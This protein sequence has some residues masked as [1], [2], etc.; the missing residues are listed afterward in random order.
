MMVLH[1]FN[2]P[3]VQMDPLM[4][5]LEICIWNGQALWIVGNLSL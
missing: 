3:F 5:T 4:K 1:T 2:K